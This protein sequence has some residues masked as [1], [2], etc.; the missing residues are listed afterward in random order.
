MVETAAPA[1]GKIRA[2]VMKRLRKWLFRLVL[3]V[4]TSGVRSC[5]M[6]I[7][8]METSGVRSCFMHIEVMAGPGQETHV[9]FLMCTLHFLIL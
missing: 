7:E 8:V 3:G 6:H 5:F 9:N 4:E 2:R 1:P